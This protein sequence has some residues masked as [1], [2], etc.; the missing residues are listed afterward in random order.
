MIRYRTIEKLV[1]ILASIICFIFFCIYNVIDYFNSI[2]QFT[3]NI[4]NS[5]ISEEKWR[6][7]LRKLFTVYYRKD[8]QQLINA[9]TTRDIHVHISCYAIAQQLLGDQRS[10]IFQLLLLYFHPNIRYCRKNCLP[11]SLCTII[12]K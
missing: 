5:F 10:Y 11:L 3:P 9:C 6:K 12:T 8:L 1:N 2:F 4:P 7:R